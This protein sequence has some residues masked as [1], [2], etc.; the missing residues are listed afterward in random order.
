[1]APLTALAAGGSVLV[2]HSRFRV[3]VRTYRVILLA[4]AVRPCRRMYITVLYNRA[5]GL[6]TLLEQLESTELWHPLGSKEFFGHM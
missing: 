4:V 2:R 5:A 1:M 6:E 3:A